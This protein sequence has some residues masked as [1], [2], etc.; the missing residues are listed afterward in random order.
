MAAVLD[1]THRFYYLGNF[2]QVLDWLA[3]R[4]G[5]LLNAEERDFITAFPG[6][7]LASRALFVRMMM[8]KGELFRVSKLAYPE[9]DSSLQALR[10]L[11]GAWVEHDPVLSLQQFAQL[12]TRAELLVQ[13]DS[14]ALRSPACKALRKDAL[15]SLLAE[16][17]AHGHPRPFSQWQH[18]GSDQAVRLLNRPLCER[19]RLMFFGNLRQDW[20][21]FVLADIGTLRYERVALGP[22]ARGFRS[23]GDIDL[24]LQLHACRQAYEAGTAAGSLLPMLPHGAFDNP[25]LDSRRQRLMFRIGQLFE[26]EQDLSQAHAVYAGCAYPG[27]RARAIRVLEKLGRFGAAH[28]LLRTAQQSP[29][30]EAERQHLARIAPRLA[31]QLGQPAPARPRAAAVDRLDLSLP[32]QGAARVEQAVGDYLQRQQPQAPVFYVENVLAN[33]LFGLLCWEAIFAAVPGAFFHPFQREPADL[34]SAD[35]HGRRRVQFER[36]L[37]RLDDGS[38][39][40]AILA[41]HEVKAGIQSPFVAWGGIT[42]DL[43][44]LALD[45]IPPPHLRWWCLRILEDVRENRSGFPDLI[46]FW[47]QQRSYRM[48]EVKGPGDKL[49]DNQLRWLDYCARHGMPVSVCYLQWEA[50]A[51]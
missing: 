31:R 7:P 28:S 39:R 15:L 46:Q 20:S 43:L 6:L 13:F 30:S 51:A 42:R 32:R 4:Y 16:D 50:L 29:E 45:C 8:R 24:Y 41:T 11:P 22:E 38:H 36:C 48:I 14:P 2:Q 35:F 9:I 23:R 17:A 21:E 33:A 5:D 26:K 47:P 19:L 18:K 12:S 37:S 27:A 10:G 3:Q 1:P 40:A 49:Q 34:F 44:E 25:W